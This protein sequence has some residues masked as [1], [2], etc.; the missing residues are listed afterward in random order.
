[1]DLPLQKRD[2]SAMVMNVFYQETVYL[3][4]LTAAMETSWIH[5]N[6]G[7]ITLLIPSHQCR[8]VIWYHDESIFYAHDRQHKTW[9]HKDAS[10]V[11]YKKGDGA[12][13]MIAN[14][15]TADFGW[16]QGINGETAWKTM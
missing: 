5:E 14:Y 12:S 7:S 10:V 13:F 3:P 11:P 8:T 2:N 9:Y 4:Q 1:M 16:L 15:I 6:N